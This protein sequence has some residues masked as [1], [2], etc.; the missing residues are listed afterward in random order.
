M[1]Y[2]YDI[3]EVTKACSRGEEPTFAINE[4]N[5]YS[6]FLFTFYQY[7]YK[8]NKEFKHISYQKEKDLLYYFLRLVSKISLGYYKL[9]YDYK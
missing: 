4:K 8:T 9:T 2:Y 6:L 5:K 1:K 3:K 7:K